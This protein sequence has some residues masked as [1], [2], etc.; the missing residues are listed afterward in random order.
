[1]RSE[2]AKSAGCPGSTDPECQCQAAG[3]AR[4][5]LGDA[6]KRGGTKEV[7]AERK[8]TTRPRGSG[9]STPGPDRTAGDSIR[10]RTTESVAAV[11]GKSR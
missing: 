6:K 4:V 3:G 8:D 10:I 1:M 7:A 11:P 5:S 9:M 2:D